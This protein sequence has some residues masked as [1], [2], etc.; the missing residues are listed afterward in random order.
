MVNLTNLALLFGVLMAWS[1]L[2]H[3]T[4]PVNWARA[5]IGIIGAAGIGVAFA[6]SDFKVIG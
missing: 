3:Y 4:V 5:V 2:L 1:T 6:L